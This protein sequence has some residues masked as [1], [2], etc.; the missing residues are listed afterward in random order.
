MR[1]RHLLEV[2]EKITAATKGENESLNESGTGT[3]IRTESDN[4]NN[5][6]SA[7]RNHI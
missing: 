1:L 3:G 5:L 7:E 4:K 6:N 2:E